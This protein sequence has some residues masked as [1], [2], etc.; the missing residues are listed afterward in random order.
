MTARAYAYNVGMV[1]T[2]NRPPCRYRVASLA[3]ISGTNMRCRLSGGVGTVMACRAVSSYPHMVELC[4]NPRR[5]VVA[6]IAG[7]GGRNMCWTFA[8]RDDAIMAGSTR[9][10]DL[11]MIDRNRGNP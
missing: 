3:N 11:R 5:G 4:T 2:R 7:R 10:N 8:A 1:D 9:P 6:R